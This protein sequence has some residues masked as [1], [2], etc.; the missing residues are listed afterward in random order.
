MF[1]LNRTLDLANLTAADHAMLGDLQVNILKGHGREFVRLLF[2]T[3]NPGASAKEA[4]RNFTRAMGNMVT[5]AQQQL[6]SAAFFKA[7]K[8]V[9][10]RPMTDPVLAFFLTH[11]GYQALGLDSRSPNHLPYRQGLKLRRGEVNDP[12]TAKWTKNLRN[13][14]HAMVLIGGNLDKPKNSWT[15]KQADEKEKLVRSLLKTCATVVHSETGRAIKN[16]IKDGKQGL[17]HF[18]YVDGRSQPLFIKGDIDF[19]LSGEK[20]APGIRGWNPAFNLNRLMFRDPGGTGEHSMGSFFVMRKL[21][22]D[23][24]LF[25]AT[26]EALQNELNNKTKHPFP[27]ALKNEVAGAMIVGRFENGTPITLSDTEKD[28]QV[29]NA[30]V[31]NNFS[32]DNDPIGAKCPFHGHIRKTNP[33]G[34][35]ASE[36]S[37]IMARRGITY[38]KRKLNAD[39]SLSQAP[40]PSKNVGL[41]F[42]AY[43]VDI[44]EQF[45]FTQNSWANNSDF[46][47]PGVGPDPLI[48]QGNSDPQHNRLR[49][50]D[51]ACPIVDSHFANCVHMKGGEYFF[52]PS[53]SFLQTI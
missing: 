21:E 9:V 49:W 37:H 33:R 22:Q 44:A 5:S 1:D 46:Q 14:I 42:M 27:G 26:E 6:E 11:K 24:K 16:G 20:L 29:P 51:P 50:N 47:Q 8:N 38:G 48:G 12:P 34:T 40:E 36:R 39:G 23:V 41:L 13:D 18:G 10:P 30:S 53:R 4:A 25:K 19:E 15:S 2:I 43:N 32:Y 17:E 3:F 31:S 7:T 45:E 35:T 52:A 28:M